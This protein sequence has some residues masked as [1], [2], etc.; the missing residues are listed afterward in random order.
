MTKRSTPPSALYRPRVGELVRDRLTGEVGEH[1]ETLGNKVFLRP[2]GGGVEWD[3]PPS[4][5][6]QYVAAAGELEPA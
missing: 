2:V 1:M 5:I 6:E 4:E 3:T